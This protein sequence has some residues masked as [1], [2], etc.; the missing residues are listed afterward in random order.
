[1]KKITDKA[2]S[3]FYGVTSQTLYNYKKS[4]NVEKNNLYKAIKE[5]YY[6]HSSNKAAELYKAALS[7]KNFSEAIRKSSTTT[8]SVLLALF[9]KVR[10]SSE[11]L[12]EEIKKCCD[13]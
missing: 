9:N 13:L 8:D 10:E 2:L 6:L 7:V 11:L 4:Q 3:E 12:E 5:Y 1:M